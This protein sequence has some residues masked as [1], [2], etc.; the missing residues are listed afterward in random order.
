MNDVT[1]SLRVLRDVHGALQRLAAHGRDQRLYRVVMEAWLVRVDR[2]KQPDTTKLTPHSLSLLH[3]S[4]T[5][6]GRAKKREC[7][8]PRQPYME[9]AVSLSAFCRTSSCSRLAGSRS[10]CRGWKRVMSQS[11]LL[12]EDG[13]DMKWTVWWWG[14]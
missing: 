3:N 1:T 6:M 12:L 7:A 10:A 11:G 8:K 5:A 4:H 2:N 13:L 14:K 9:L